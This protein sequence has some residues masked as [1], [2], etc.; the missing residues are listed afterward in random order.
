VGVVLIHCTALHV[1]FPLPRADRRS[2]FRPPEPVLASTRALSPSA[3]QAG[4]MRREIPGGRCQRFALLD[5]LRTR[6]RCHPA[7]ATRGFR[8]TSRLLFD[9]DGNDA[10]EQ[11][12]APP[13]LALDERLCRRNGVGPAN[14]C[15]IMPPIPKSSWPLSS[16]PG[17]IACP[18]RC[19]RPI[20]HGLSLF[21]VKTC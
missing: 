15:A 10:L 17:P 2:R 16:P 5:A 11:R 20:R 21:A 19:P 13:S 3:A 4:G 6:R 14:M 18:S 9:G 7:S 12:L 1:D 8:S